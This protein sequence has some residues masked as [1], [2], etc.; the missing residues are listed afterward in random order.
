[1]ATVLPGPSTIETLLRVAAG[2]GLSGSD[3]IKLEILI[4]WIHSVG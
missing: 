1:M 4:N 3:N 2:E